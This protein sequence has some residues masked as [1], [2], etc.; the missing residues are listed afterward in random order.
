MRPPLH[1]SAQISYA[2]TAALAIG[3]ADAT[4][5]ALHVAGAHRTFEYTPSRTWVVAPLCW[6]L[7]AL[8]L[9]LPALLI[10]RARAA[11][12]VVVAMIAIGVTARMETA[13]TV[14]RAGMATA[15][16]VPPRVISRDCG[17]SVILDRWHFIVHDS[18]VEEVFDMV[19]DPSEAAPLP[20]DRVPA[21][22]MARLRA[23]ALRLRR[24]AA[25][26]REEPFRAL[27]YVQ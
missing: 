22:V 4:T 6:A 8:V 7:V 10:A 20:A 23:E 18:G 5:I 14:P 21:E 27:G 1:V 24:S 19:S 12:A 26:G 17:W 2:V 16:L 25:A 11:S 15:V 13:W 3:L 9:L